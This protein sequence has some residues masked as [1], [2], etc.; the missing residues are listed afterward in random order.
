MNAAPTSRACGG[1]DVACIPAAG[2]QVEE[3]GVAERMAGQHGH[4]NFQHHPFK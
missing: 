4:V 3:E 2:A 1:G